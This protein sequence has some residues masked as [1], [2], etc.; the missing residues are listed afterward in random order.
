M[1]NGPRVG[2]KRRRVYCEHC[3]EYLKKSTYYRH[4]RRFF[5][6]QSKT[7]AK[8]IQALDEDPSTS[9]SL[10]SN[11]EIPFNCDFEESVVFESDLRVTEPASEGVK[12]AQ[13]GS[14][15]GEFIINVQQ[16]VHSVQHILTIYFSSLWGAIYDTLWQA[17]ANTYGGVIKSRA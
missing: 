17:I 1:E 6:P 5:D 7:W 3:V 16:A 4:K 9:T 11:D 2:D 13:S 12:F 8:E 14:V 15:L 10:D